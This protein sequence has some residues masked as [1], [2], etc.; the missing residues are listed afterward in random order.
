MIIVHKSSKYFA[1]TIHN[2]K[3]GQVRIVHKKLKENSLLNSF[4]GR[5]VDLSFAH[6][7]AEVLL[8]CVDESGCLQIFKITLDAESKMQTSIVFHLSAPPPPINTSLEMNSIEST[9]GSLS[10]TDK[11]NTLDTTSRIIWCMYIPD[12]SENTQVPNYTDASK[13]FVLT[14]R[15]RA[16]IFN[17]SLIEKEHDCSRELTSDEITTGHLIIDEHKSTI[18]SVSLSPDGTAVATSCLDGEV[19]FFKISF[20]PISLANGNTQESTNSLLNDQSDYATQPKCLK[21][22]YPHDKKSVTSLYFLE[23]HNISSSN[24]QLWNL[25]LT[26]ADYNREIK[27]WCC[28]KWECM[29]TIR[30]SNQSP[31]VDD[32]LRSAN[33]QPQM[34]PLPQIKTS[35]DLSSKYLVLSDLTRKCFYVLHLLTDVENDE[36]KCTAISEFILAYP[37]VSFAIIDSQEIKTRKYNQLNNVNTNNN[38]NASLINE[39]L[40]SNKNSLSISAANDMLNASLSSSSSMLPQLSQAQA[41]DSENNYLAT[42]IRLYCIQTKQLQEMTIFLNGEQ[43]VNA[44]SNSS[45]SPTPQLNTAV[46]SSGVL[47]A[48]AS[49]NG[50]NSSLLLHQTLPEV[51]KNDASMDNESYEEEETFKLKS[52]LGNNSVTPDAFLN[53]LNNKIENPQSASQHTIDKLRQTTSFVNSSVNSRATHDANLVSTQVPSATNLPSLA[54]P[55]FN[56]LTGMEKF[57]EAIRILEIQEQ[58]ASQPKININLNFLFNFQQSNNNSSNKRGLGRGLLAYGENE[59]NSDVNTLNLFSNRTSSLTQV[60]SSTNLNSLSPSAQGNQ[61]SNSLNKIQSSSSHFDSRKSPHLA[62]KEITAINLP[63]PSNIFDKVTS[64]K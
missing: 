22:W 49:Q 60:T 54:S 61:S 23:D 6:Y 34:F 32:A 7:D 46:E 39:D 48:S 36:A 8:G 63:K 40:N 55:P 26:G 35:I 33:Q 9:D 45:V 10:S 1:Y 2:D 5:V 62:D 56:R 59:L 47:L 27:L 16:D 20:D 38:N 14:R 30:F 51:S 43:S 41:Q 58:T 37:A 24:A 4:N 52:L 19:S 57:N 13:V 12:S 28:L 31:F 44:Y 17:L 29:Q 3:N 53:S 15:N 64:T 25:I 11:R 42:M 18:L 50:L 21:K